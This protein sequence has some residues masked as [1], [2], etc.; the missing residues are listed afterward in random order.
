MEPK[1]F[2]FISLAGLIGDLAWHLSKEGH[3][4]KYYI[5][6]VKIIHDIISKELVE[7]LKKLAVVMSI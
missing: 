6:E 3:N 5:K 7:E 2:L 1:N 4:V